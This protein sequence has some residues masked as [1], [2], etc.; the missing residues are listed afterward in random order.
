MSLL[1]LF[2]VS[3]WGAK[4]VWGLVSSL[5]S[6]EQIEGFFKKMKIELRKITEE[7]KTGCVYPDKRTQHTLW[8]RVLFPQKFFFS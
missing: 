1:R 5:F 3:F 8:G 4:K 6:W 2:G 7:K